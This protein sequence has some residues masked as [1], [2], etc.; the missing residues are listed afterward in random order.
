MSIAHNSQTRL[1]TEDAWA[2]SLKIRQTFIG[3]A[4]KLGLQFAHFF[5]TG[6]PQAIGKDRSFTINQGERYGW[7]WLM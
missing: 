4:M 6:M 3:S 2:Y 7:V 1:T 5:N